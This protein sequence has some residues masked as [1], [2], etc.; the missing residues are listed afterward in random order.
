VIGCF[1]FGSLKLEQILSSL[2]LFATQVMP[3]RDRVPSVPAD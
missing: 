3:I 1:A 2:E